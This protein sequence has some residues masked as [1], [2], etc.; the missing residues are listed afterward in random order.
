ML[1]LHRLVLLLFLCYYSSSVLVD[2]TGRL[3]GNSGLP[4]K[5]ERELPVCG[6]REPGESPLD[7][8]TLPS[9]EAPVRRPSGAHLMAT[10]ATSTAAAKREVGK[11]ANSGGGI[12]EVTGDAGN[13]GE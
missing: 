12:S 8:D 7:K 10:D 6:R 1:P 13:A 3:G 9:R 2:M 11:E 4:R 5:P